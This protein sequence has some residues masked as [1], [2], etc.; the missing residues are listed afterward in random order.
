MADNTTLPGTGDIV[1]D[2][3]RAGVKTQVMALDMGGADGESLLGPDN[4]LPVSDSGILALLRSMLRLLSSPRG[5]D[6][7]LGRQRVTAVVESGAITTVT[8]VTTVAT[9]TTLSQIAGRDAGTMLINP[10]NRTS[11]ALNHR[12]RIT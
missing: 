5:Y 10:T 4:P 6:R 3:D 8:T 11:W 7:S 9:I 12:S 2:L 1:R